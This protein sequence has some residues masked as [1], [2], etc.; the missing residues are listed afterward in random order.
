MILTA[1]S[2]GLI[3]GISHASD[4]PPGILSARILPGW[5]DD[6]GQRVAAVELQ[7][8]PGWK[9]YWRQ[10]GDSGLPPS[11]DWQGS[12]NL[13]E[14]TIH[15][16]APEAIHS[17]DELTLGYHDRLVLPFTAS[18]RQHG[19][20]IDLSLSMDFGVC[21]K[22]CVPA[23]VTLNAPPPDMS[24]D[25]RITAALARVPQAS[26]IVPSCRLTPIED[27][28]QLV[29]SLPQTQVDVAAMEIVDSPEIWVSTPLLRANS[30]GTEATAELVGP[31]AQPFDLD[32]G[33]LRITLIDE[34]GATEMRGCLPS[35]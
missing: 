34:L 16:P 30:L 15:W 6:N 21:E 20:A 7:L 33:Q 4:L 28:L 2:L 22:I 13:E 19:T 27:G 5:T 9:T 31:S 29:V 23:H 26:D 35:G 8:E 24:S 1:L 11:F 3:A 18:P 25:P 32:T 10:P 14:L 17:G 12:N